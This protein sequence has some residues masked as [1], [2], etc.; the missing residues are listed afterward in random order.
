MH[1]LGKNTTLDSVENN[2]KKEV[3]HVLCRHNHP[4]PISHPRAAQP[5]WDCLN[6]G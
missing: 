6:L 2:G 3:S 4:G 5:A 1:L